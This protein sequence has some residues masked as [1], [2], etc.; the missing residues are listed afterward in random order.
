M[1]RQTHFGSCSVLG[2]S[3]RKG[4]GGKGDV[5]RQAGREGGRDL[6]RSALEL[7]GYLGAEIT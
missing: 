6:F 4:G 7:K 3:F 1:H 5:D 2:S